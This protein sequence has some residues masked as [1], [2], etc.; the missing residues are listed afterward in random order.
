MFKRRVARHYKTA[1][2]MAL[3]SA[4][5]VCVSPVKILLLEL[6]RHIATFVSVAK[7]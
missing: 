4:Q 6:F 1:F 2:S 7:I 5:R 3:D